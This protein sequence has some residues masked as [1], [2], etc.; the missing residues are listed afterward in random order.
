MVYTVIH[1]FADLQDG[2]HIYREG[3][4]FPR[5]G[6]KPTSSR[7]AEL[8]SNGN[9]IG[10]ALIAEKIETART[11]E[12]EAEA[13]QPEPEHKRQGRRKKNSAEA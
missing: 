3:D 11:P 4:T 12:P 10:T 13:E 2:E 6:V 9:R 5:S 1:D 7:I 8:L